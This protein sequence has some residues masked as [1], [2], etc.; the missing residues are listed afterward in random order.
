MTA[1]PCLTRRSLRTICALL[2]FTLPTGAL[3][4]QNAEPTWSQE[5]GMRI[6]QQV[7]KKLGGLTNFSVFDWI[8]FGF[9]GK[10]LVLKGYASRPI[11]KRTPKMP[12]RGF[13]ES[14]PSIIRSKSC[15]TLPMT[16]ASVPL[17]TTVSTR[18]PRYGNTTPIKVRS[19]RP[20]DPVAAA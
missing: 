2:V 16:T 5:D 3:I 12:S 10:T 17:S 6:V 8:T 11:L 18:S 4:A 7:Q 13:R 20:L 19:R 1:L 15:R 14:T 9:H